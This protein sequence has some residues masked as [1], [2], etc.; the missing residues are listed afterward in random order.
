MFVALDG[1]ERVQEVSS[2]QWWECGDEE[3][4][5]GLP[6]KPYVPPHIVRVVSSVKSSVL[7]PCRR[8]IV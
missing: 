6:L 4:F 1:D 8:V 5:V 7:Y 2:V 3:V